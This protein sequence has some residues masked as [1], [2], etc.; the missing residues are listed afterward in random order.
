[1]DDN[2]LLFEFSFD[3]PKGCRAQIFRQLRS[4][5]IPTRYTIRL[6]RQGPI[7]PKTK[8]PID[9]IATMDNGFGEE[10]FEPITKGV[11]T[12]NSPSPMDN[13][14]AEDAFEDL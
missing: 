9:L 4:K 2:E 10:A 14:V 6:I 11:S 8:G 13:G 5:H 1:M 7:P 3:V 12:T